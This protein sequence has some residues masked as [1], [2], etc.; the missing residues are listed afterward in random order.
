MRRVCAME[1]ANCA[2]VEKLA[3]SALSVAA[4]VPVMRI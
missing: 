1:T 2:S 3:V 4:S